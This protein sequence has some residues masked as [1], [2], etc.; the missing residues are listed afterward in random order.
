M[1]NLTRIAASKFPNSP[2]NID[3]VIAYFNHP[4]IKTTTGKTL[5]PPTEP[6]SDFFKLAFKSKDFAYCLFAADDVIEIIKTIEIDRRM[7]SDGTFKITPL[8][9]F[10]QVLMLSVDICGQ[11]SLLIFSSM[12][13]LKI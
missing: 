4:S 1:R 7:Y 12:K 5:R 11:V 9:D 8:G 10:S 6:S 2:N 13:L 3:E